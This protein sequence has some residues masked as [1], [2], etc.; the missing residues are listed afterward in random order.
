MAVI[1]GT[2]YPI[3]K[4]AFRELDPQAFNA[5]RMSIAATTFLLVM[6]I[7]RMAGRRRGRDRRDPQGILASTFHTPAPVTHRDWL[8]LA[9]LGVVG[10][11]LYQYFFIGG[12]ARTSVANSSLI[13]AATPVL[14][15]LVS[16]A[17][18]EEHVGPAHWL[19]AAASAFGIYLVVGQGMALGGGRLVGD[20]MVVAA[21]CCWTIYTLGARPLME[22]HSPVAVTGLS[23]AIGALLYVP[24][25]WPTVRATDWT[26]VSPMTWILLM[27][28]ALFGLCLA[29]T[30][31]YAGVR[32]IGS[33]RT[34]VYSNL[35][36]LVAM[37]SA[38]IFLHEPVGMRKVLG[39]I[40]VLAGVALT[41]AGAV[42]GQ[43]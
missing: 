6:A 26:A 8:A 40:A 28:S 23:M 10:H 29:Y 16:A 36:P 27:Y 41:R 1:W 35:V 20:L 11:V 33:A 5:V 39:A 24:V 30:I 42:T 13:I 7:A 38:A 43:E 34:S 4:G 2:N 9:G 25:M 17:I 18:G 19:G 37:S 21:V 3:I 12:L 32:Q 14:I 22:R 15:A 31:W